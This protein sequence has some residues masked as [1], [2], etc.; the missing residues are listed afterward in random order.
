MKTKPKKSALAIDISI[1]GVNRAQKALF[2]KHLA[3]MLESGL[4]ITEALVV[5]VDSA[6]GKFKRI[7]DASHKKD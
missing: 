4:T 5:I 6:Q 2:A 7:Y 1:G 3:V